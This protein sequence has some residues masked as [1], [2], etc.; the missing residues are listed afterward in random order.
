[1]RQQQQEAA[2]TRNVIRFRNLM[3]K[4]LERDM[5]ELAFGVFYG[6]SGYGKTTSAIAS[7]VAH[8]AHYVRLGSSWGIKTL[9]DALCE[10]LGLKT[11]GTSSAALADIVEQLVLDPGRPIILD[12][13]DYLIKRDQVDFIR[14]IVDMSATPIILIGEETLPQK[15]RKWERAHNRVMAFEAAQPT[16]I[17]EARMFA[18]IRAP[19]LS[20]KDDLLTA[21]IEGCDGRARR[22]CRSIDMAKEMAKLR[23]LKAVSRADWGTTPFFDNEPPKRRPQ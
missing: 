14:D 23:H 8:H 20:I 18:R 6:P 10:R 11:R 12:E 2:P 15:L 17:A 3:K 7:A 9:A 19:D 1:M 4:L 16:D 21:M 22:I 5:S 13:A